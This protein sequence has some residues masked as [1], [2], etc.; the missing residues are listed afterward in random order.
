MFVEI[1]LQE[2]AGKFS[3]TWDLKSSLDHRLRHLIVYETNELVLCA[4]YNFE[5]VY[6]LEVKQ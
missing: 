6:G 3:R 4:E 1:L 2:E 5:T